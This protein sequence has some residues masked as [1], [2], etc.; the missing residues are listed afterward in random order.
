MYDVRP[1]FVMLDDLDSR[2]SLS[3]EHGV[4]ASKIE[5]TL[6]KTVAGL[7]GPNRQLGRVFICTITS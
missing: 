5:E 1:D 4:I 7:G 6:G 3:A 2:D